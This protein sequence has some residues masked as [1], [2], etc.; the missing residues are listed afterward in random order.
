MTYTNEKP[1]TPGW[2]WYR[3]SP[4]HDASIIE[5]YDFMAGL[6][7]QRDGYAVG[8]YQSHGQFA[9]P[10]PEPEEYCRGMINE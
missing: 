2:Y 7:Y 6:E 5:I 3:E 8:V 1:T 10:I 9:G 4:K